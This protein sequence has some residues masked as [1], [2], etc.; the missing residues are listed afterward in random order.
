MRLRLFALGLGIWM[1]FTYAVVGLV[2]SFLCFQ[3]IDNQV[4]NNHG[5]IQNDLLCIE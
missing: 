5:N 3:T 1:Y 2:S 4:H